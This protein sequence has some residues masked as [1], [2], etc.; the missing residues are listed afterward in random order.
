MMSLGAIITN[1]LAIATPGQ[2]LD[3][4]RGQE[5]TQQES[6]CTRYQNTSQDPAPILSFQLVTIC[7]AITSKCS[8]REA[9]TKTT[10]PE[11]KRSN[12]SEAEF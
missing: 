1:L 12:S 11:S 7:S 10:S 3:K 6:E 9:L 8:A 4:Q 5:E 2:E